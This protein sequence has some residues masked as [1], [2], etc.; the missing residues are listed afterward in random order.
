MIIELY[1]SNSEPHRVD[2]DLT[3]LEIFEGNLKN[4]TSI[5]N[6][7]ILIESHKVETI[8]SCNY[9]YISSF[10]RYYFVNN[11]VSVRTGLWS[12]SCHV[13][14]LMTYR[15]QFRSL[16]AIIARQENLYNL[17]LNDDRFLIDAQRIYQ[18]KVFPNSVSAA[19][20]GG[21]SFI[22]TLAGGAS[23]GT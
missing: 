1:R 22:L 16:S 21:K 17:Y 8:T 19:T 18:T 3:T 10:G 9:I 23:S 11:I 4:E 15:K 2:K 20:S 6:P 13:D 5:I 12:F 14:V 7:T